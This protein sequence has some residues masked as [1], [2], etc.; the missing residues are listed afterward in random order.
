MCLLAVAA[1]FPSCNNE[2]SAE[3]T[4][5]SLTAKSIRA[6][7]AVNL[8]A[9][10][11]SRSSEDPTFEDGND[12]EN[13]ASEA[14]FYFFNADGEPYIVRTE[15]GT[16][17]SYVDKNITLNAQ[18]PTDDNIE[19]TSTAVL[20]IEKQLEAP[21]SIIAVLN[22][23]NAG[24]GSAPA[25]SE[26][27]LCGIINDYSLDNATVNGA[28]VMSNS[29]YAADGKAVASTALK[30]E[31]V[32]SYVM[33]SNDETIKAAE[34]KANAHPVDI[35]VERVLAKVI[36]TDADNKTISS[37]SAAYDTKTSVTLADG[38]D[39]KKTVSVIKAKITGW[40][41]Y[42]EI[43]KSYLIKNIDTS[44]TDDQLGFSWNDA[45]RFRSYW[46]ST[47]TTDVSYTKTVAY[48]KTF[49]S[50]N[51]IYPQENTSDTKTGVIVAA[52]LQDE[53]GNV[54]E[55]AEY[56]DSRMTVPGLKNTIANAVNIYYVSK[57]TTT[58][59]T[60]S[61][62]YI[63]VTETTYSKISPD[64]ISF[65]STGDES[66]KVKAVLAT[67]SSDTTKF[68][69]LQSNGKYVAYQSTSSVN[70]VLADYEAG[71][72]T[73]GMTY[74]YIP[75]RHLA[76][77]AEKDGYRGI[78]R[79]HIYKVQITGIEGLGTPVYNPTSE[80]ITKR[81]ETPIDNKSYISAKIHVL[82]WRIVKQETEL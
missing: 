58:T 65:Q 78:V 25:L 30:E 28:F 76:S 37:S 56:N 29:V 7:I 10:Q 9:N 59:S 26:S 12:K 17:Y 73:E 81:E 51:A 14:R 62:S 31:N 68:Y 57:T 70:N 44:W 43:D 40:T 74:Y 36:L 42:N 54:V 39:G 19:E 6:C 3:K 45:P 27:E 46:A 64:H 38:N 72:Y 33:G 79:N 71:I 5:N 75:I 48:P 55:I 63:T 41:L 50:G 49:P 32:I 24:L 11:T 61:S 69:Y 16:S 82:S 35:Y 13:A 34:A 1:T 21:A 66:H 80:T 52:Q 77:D 53:Q 20:V 4:D 8:V 60:T 2:E 47:P 18:T 15:N 22:P 67:G 23:D